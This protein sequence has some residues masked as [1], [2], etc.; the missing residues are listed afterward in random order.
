MLEVIFTKKFNPNRMVTKEE[1]PDAKMRF[2]H[3][4]KAMYRDVEAVMAMMEV[5]DERLKKLE[6]QDLECLRRFRRRG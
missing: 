5:R 1:C 2:M 3:N 6:K 4:R